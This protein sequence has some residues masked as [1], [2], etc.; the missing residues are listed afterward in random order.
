MELYG[1]VYKTDRYSTSRQTGGSLQKVHP[2]NI[3]TQ[4]Q[5]KGDVKGKL[6]EIACVTALRGRESEIWGEQ[7][8]GQ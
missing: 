3:R 8:E 4:V 1:R 7:K 2:N 6:R 5:G